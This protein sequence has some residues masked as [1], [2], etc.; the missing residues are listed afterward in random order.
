MIDKSVAGYYPS[1][2]KTWNLVDTARYSLIGGTVTPPSLKIAGQLL[3]IQVDSGQSSLISK[4]HNWN[5]QYPE[6]VAD[7]LKVEMLEALAFA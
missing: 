7:F 6:L 5:G 2:S 4:C 3:I 1:A